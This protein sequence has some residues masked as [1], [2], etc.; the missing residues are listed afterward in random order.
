MIIICLKVFQQLLGNSLYN[1]K[2]PQE[3]QPQPEFDAGARE[4][5]VHSSL[6]FAGE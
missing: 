3:C 1:K 5:Q 2:K 4:M 6:N